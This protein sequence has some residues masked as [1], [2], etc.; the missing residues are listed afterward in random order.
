MFLQQINYNNK[1]KIMKKEKKILSV[2][3]E[4]KSGSG[5]NPENKFKKNKSGAATTSITSVIE[6]TKA[7]SGRGTA[8]EGTL[9]SYD[10]ER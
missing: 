4:K 2:S 8:N 3:K 1:K 10:K 9:V 6:Q 7:K 5:S